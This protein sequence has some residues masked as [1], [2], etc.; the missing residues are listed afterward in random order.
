MGKQPARSRNPREDSP[1]AEP[2][3]ARNHLLPLHRRA[4]PRSGNC[5]GNQRVESTGGPPTHHLRPHQPWCRA[6]NQNQALESR[7][8]SRTV[9]L[10]NRE[11][12]GLEA[13][14]QATSARQGNPS[15]PCECCEG[16]VGRS[17]IS[18]SGGLP[19]LGASPQASAARGQGSATSGEIPACA[20]IGVC[21][22]GDGRAL[23]WRRPATTRLA[24][25]QTAFIRPCW[26]ESISASLGWTRLRRIIG[27][28]YA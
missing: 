18:G 24:G 17:D 6:W 1:L 2:V 12:H 27:M 15:H 10:A 26:G 4:A 19:E 5:A 28:N 23:G 11:F 25:L 13:A 16:E 8:K 7:L 14:P 3:L 21:Q 22:L 20:E 9:G